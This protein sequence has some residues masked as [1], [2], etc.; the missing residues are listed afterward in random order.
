MLYLDS[1]A[2]MKR[3]VI[4]KGSGPL[5]ARFERGENIYTSLLSF[6]EIHTALARAFRMERLTAEDLTRSR[7]AFLNDWLFGMSAIEVNIHTMTALPGLVENY[8]L[9]AADA[10]HLSAAIWLRDRFRLR[11][12]RPVHKDE[13]EFGVADTRLSQA[14]TKCGL[15]VFNPELFD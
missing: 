7:E 15:L 1:S 9:K 12:H 2:L 13:V 3:Y 11:G 14:A 6:G 4:E 10:I 5:S 8:L